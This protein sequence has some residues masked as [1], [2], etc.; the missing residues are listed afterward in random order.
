MDDQDLV[1]V[2]AYYTSADEREMVLHDMTA[3]APAEVQEYGGLL[4]GSVNSSTAHPLGC[5]QHRHRGDR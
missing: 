4:E 1:S 3:A 5:E 2:A